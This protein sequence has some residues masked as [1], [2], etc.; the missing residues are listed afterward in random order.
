M[1]SKFELSSRLINIL[2]KWTSVA[3]ESDYDKLL[4]CSGQNQY[5]H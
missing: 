5:S 3:V 2:V 4:C 1:Y